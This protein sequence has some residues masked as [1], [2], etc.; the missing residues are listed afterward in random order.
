MPESF[1]VA[2][3]KHTIFFDGSTGAGAELISAEWSDRTL[4]EEIPRVER[5]VAQ[6]FEDRSVELVCSRLRDDDHL[7]ACTLSILGGV[8]TGQYIEFANGVDSQQIPAHAAGGDR[9]L[10]RAGILDSI[11]QKQIFQRT[12]ARDGKCIALARNGT[13]TLVGVID[14]SGIQRDQIVKASAVER[15]VFHFTFSNESCHRCGRRID[16]RSLQRNRYLL[17]EFT[18]LELQIDDGLLTDRQIDSGAY[19]SAES[20]LL[21]SNVVRTHGQREGSV[22]AHLVGHN[23]ACR[24]GFDIFHSDDCSPNRRARGVLHFSRYGRRHLGACE[25]PTRSENHNRQQQSAEAWFGHSGR[26]YIRK[27]ALLT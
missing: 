17:R 25:V 8:C 3:E 24:A 12:P 9:K 1:I 27:T 7:R 16:E 21:R 19:G 20:R 23:R 22:I 15:Q 2:E 14:R 11:H 13:G 10:A 26:V 6:K 5:A 4:I 18:D